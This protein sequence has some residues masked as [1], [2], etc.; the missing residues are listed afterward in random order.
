[1]RFD[2]YY[3]SQADQFSFIRIPRS[4]LTDETFSSLSIPSKLLYG[5][6]L[7]RMGLSMKN[8]WFDELNRVYIIYQIAEIQ[9]DLALSKKKAISYLNELEQ[10][11]LVEKKRRGLGLPSILY[12][13]SFLVDRDYS[14]N[15]IEQRSDDKGECLD[16]DH[17]I[18]YGTARSAYSDSSVSA[19]LHTDSLSSV[20]SFS[21][22]SRRDD[23]GSSEMVPKQEDNDQDND[24]PASCEYEQSAEI[25]EKSYDSG[26]SSASITASDWIKMQSFRGAQGSTSRC[27]GTNNCRS[28]DLGISRGVRKDTSGSTGLGTSRGAETALQEVPD[29]GLLKNNTKANNTEYSYTES[30]H[31]LSRPALPDANTVDEIDTMDEMRAY[32]HIIKQNI[33]YD[34]LLRRYPHEQ[35]LIEGILD[36]ILEVVLSKSRTLFIASGEYPAELVRSKFLKL[37]Y[38]HIEYVLSCFQANTTKVKNIKKYLL[39]ALFNAPSTISG[40]YSAQVHHDM[41]YLAAEGG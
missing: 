29:Q 8:G 35:D 7:D 24:E 9:E 11:G 34:D 10:F 19:D 13:K 36:L 16:E 14:K 17:S 2:Y 39:A 5:L 23:I 22:I 27:I 4:L 18:H 3:G 33:A 15:G 21:R 12:V 31:I 38:S 40:Y 1:M 37:D 26:I 28:V 32:T 6:L 41:P 25:E 20:C 30:N